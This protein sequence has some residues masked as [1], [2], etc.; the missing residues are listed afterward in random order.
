MGQLCRFRTADVEADGTF[1]S[2]PYPPAAFAAFDALTVAA[3]GQ[4]EIASG[5][6]AIIANLTAVAGSSYT[7]LTLYPSAETKPPTTSDINVATGQVQPNLTAVQLSDPGDF[8]IYNASGTI[9]A[10]V[11][12][13][14]HE[15]QP[16]SRVDVEPAHPDRFADLSVPPRQGLRRLED[17]P[18]SG[19]AGEVAHRVRGGGAA[20]EAAGSV[21]PH[22]A[23]HRERRMRRVVVVERLTVERRP[24]GDA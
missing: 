18:A 8:K 3:A 13:W 4:D 10:F 5:A 15:R 12:G 21:H 9:N 22:T 7:Y 17:R 23:V 11:E 2:R 14:F 19:I 6:M 1:Q 20:K 16:D 24:R